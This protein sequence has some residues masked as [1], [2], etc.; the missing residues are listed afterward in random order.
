MKR[1]TAVLLTAILLCFFAFPAMGEETGN[2]YSV[3]KK[4]VLSALY[5]AEISETVRAIKEGLIS[6]EEITRYYLS[7]I[8][9]YDADYNCFITLCDDAL[10]VAKARDKALSEG[11]AE[12]LLFG[13]PIVIK[14]NMD[15]QG[16]YTTSGNKLSKSKI[17]DKNADVVELLLNQGAVIIGKTNM[18]TNAQ[19]AR[20]SYSKIAGHT[21][22]A[23]SKYMASGGSSGGSAVATSLNF[24]AAALGTD[25]NSSLRY[26]AALNGLVSLRTTTGLVSTTGCDALVASR[27]VAGAITRTVADQALMLDVLTEGENAYYENLDDTVLKGMKIG[28]ITELSYATSLKKVRSQKNLDSEVE[29]AFENAVSELR[30][31]GAE[32]KEISMKNL[33]KLSEST[34]GS[35][36][37]VQ[38]E[39][40]YSA[41]CSLLEENDLE[42]VIFPTCLSTPIRVVDEKG[43]AL[44]YRSAT[45][46]NN[47]KILSPSTGLPEITV[48]IG[49]HSRGSGIGMEIAAKKDCEQLLLNIAYSYTEKFDHRTVP[50][51]APDSYEAYNIGT[52]DKILSDKKDFENKESEEEETILTD[53][54]KAEPKPIDAYEVVKIAALV[55]WAAALVLVT[56]A[57]ILLLSSRKKKK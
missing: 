35:G 1:I 50:V 57:T 43:K 53:T 14:D 51:A 39:K 41:F 3:D 18:S 27:D 37:N 36:K 31:L 24:A 6:C 52:L 25:T 34:F 21:F 26:P 19:D 54:E 47:C 29:V 10:A 23:Y 17:A 9:E 11:K 45:Y 28:I 13:V 44:N 40:F 42:A 48:P 5:E 30:S 16:Y 55:I 38:R 56:L 7:R 33:F 20:Q 46:I 8:K 22:N 12:G 32:V 49:L 15:L 4:A 2:Q